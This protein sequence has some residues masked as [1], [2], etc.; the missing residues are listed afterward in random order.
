[1]RVERDGAKLT[2]KLPTSTSWQYYFTHTLHTEGDAAV[3][4]ESIQRELDKQARYKSDR[5]EELENRDVANA[6]TI[7][8]LRGHLTRLRKRL[9]P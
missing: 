3:V 9:N 1:M 6:R 5:I 7:A 8:C 2:V 4:Q